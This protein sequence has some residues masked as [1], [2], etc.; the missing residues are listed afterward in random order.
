MQRFFQFACVVASL[1]LV[2]PTAEAR[3]WTDASG[4]YKVEADLLAINEDVI[5][6]KAKDSRLIAVEI[7]QLSKADQEFL[8][9]AEAGATKLDAKDKDHV[10]RLQDD[11][12]IIGRVVGYFAGDLTVER[13]N[14]RIFVDG[15]EESQVPDQL[16][17]MLPRIVENFETAK[18]KDMPSLK[19]WLSKHGK[20]PHIYPVEGVRI[21]LTS[22]E[23]LKVPIFMFAS[24]ERALLEP[25][26]VRWKA[27]QKEKMKD[28]DRSRYARRE[29]LLLSSAARAYQQDQAFKN[30]AQLMQLDMLAIDAGITDLWEVL[31]L[32]NHPYAYPFTVVVPARDSASAQAAAAARYPGFT[33]DA[34]RKLAG[35]D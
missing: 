24:A 9:S 12:K 10:W 13:R 29:A 3:Q 32:P 17:Q 15:T 31:L 35:L 14:A 25:G 7:S 26:L 20:L 5:V 16:M 19:E 27:L 30:Q 2:G 8:R 6:L 11:L 33:V 1:F 22:G 23:E 34:T 4:R 21:A 28:I 18:I